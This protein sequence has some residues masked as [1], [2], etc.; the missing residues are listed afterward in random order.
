MSLLNVCIEKLKKNE[1]KPILFIINWSLQFCSFRQGSTFSRMLILSL[2]NFDST[3][4][5]AMAVV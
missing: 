5:H 3:E 2:C 1:Q 4:S